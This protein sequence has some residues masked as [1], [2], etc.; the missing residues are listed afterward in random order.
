MGTIITISQFL[1]SLAILIT[2]HELGHFLAAR[3]FGIRVEKF[4]L[5]FDAWGFKLFKFKKGDTE[6]GIGWLPLGGY[7]KIAGMVDESLDTEQMKTAPEKWEFRSKPAW[8]RLIVMI[9]GVTVNLILGILIMI[10]I[11][12]NVGEKYIPNAVINESGGIYASPVAR[13]IGLLSGDKI[14]SLNG[15]PV[16]N[17]EVEF[18]DHNFL[19]ADR[20]EVKLNRN[21]KDTTI[22]ITANLLEKLGQKSEYPFISPPYDIHVKAVVSGTPASKAGLK[23]D[24]RIVA[25]NG[26]K[27]VMFFD[28]KERLERL[29]DSNIALTLLNEKGETREAK[30]KV[31]R[32]GTI[33]FQPEFDFFDK[34]AKEVK[35]SLGESVV[36]GVGASFGMLVTNAKG[37]G[38]VVTGQ[39]DPKKSLAGPV[40]MAQMY[41]SQWNW[42][43][44]WTLTAMISLVLAFMNILPIPA[45][46]GGHVMFLLW[47]II[48][49]RPV[50]EKVLYIGQIIGMVVLGA[51]MIFVF[52]VDIASALGF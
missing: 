13:E 25:I 27:C 6:Y 36:K 17:L 2:L 45:L 9:G 49:R 24:D 32:E 15:K 11:K 19:M 5:F 14:V 40:R 44:F 34:K 21:G 31:S 3:M 8:Q 38:K 18:L 42:L 50:N 4:Y 16:E 52:W 41:G 1:L 39:V 30:L 35:L 10:L 28:F 20:K 47:E 12:W 29:K 51:L 23:K 22:L 37:L 7:V 33:G 46:D 43:N 48:T 26:E